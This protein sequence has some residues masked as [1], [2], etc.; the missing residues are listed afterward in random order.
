MSKIELFGARQSTYLRVAWM[1]CE[2]KGA[3]YV[4]RPG[5]PHSPEILAM[6]PFGRIPAMRHGPV[7]L[8]ESKAI[9]TYVDRVVPGPALIPQ[10]PVGQARVE[11]WISAVNTSIEP[12][13]T[14]YFRAYVFP[15]GPDG[16]PDQEV[17]AAQLPTIQAH[18]HVLESVLS[19][20]AWLGGDDFTL[21]DIAILP[22]LHYLH[23]FPEGGAMAS[24]CDHLEA[25]FTTL[26][27]RPSARAT[28][29]PPM[30]EIG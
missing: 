19:G 15:K 16:T 3:S 17:I 11:Q 26:S 2:E 24:E 12:V 13:W 5:M 10:D 14:L 21:A 20:S 4:I 30:S 27:A 25:Y 8:F 6:H 1:T 29:P 9:A 18:L 23:Q 7:T 22:I 28:V